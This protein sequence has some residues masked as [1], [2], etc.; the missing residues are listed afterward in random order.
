LDNPD[1][2][3]PKI[4]SNPTLDKKILIILPDRTPKSGYETTLMWTVSC[5]S[6]KM[7]IGESH[8]EVGKLL[9]HIYR[10][11]HMISG[12]LRASLSSVVWTIGNFIFGSNTVNA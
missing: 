1:L 3:Q 5:K 10:S 8:F 6:I 9:E 4:I 2:A 12:T 11:K 7:E